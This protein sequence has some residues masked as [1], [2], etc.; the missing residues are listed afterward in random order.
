MIPLKVTRLRTRPLIVGIRLVLVCLLAGTQANAQGNDLINAAAK[1]D[2]PCVKALL[3]AKADVNAKDKDGGTALT[4]D[5][6]GSVPA[7]LIA[8]LQ[9]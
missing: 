5:A 1:G 2:S 3:D 8:S 7:C 9:T 6:D 4:T